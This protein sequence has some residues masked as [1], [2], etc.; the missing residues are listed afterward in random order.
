MQEERCHGVA[1][2]Q[3]KIK[4]DDATGDPSQRPTQGSLKGSTGVVE[5]A[6]TVLGIYR[7]AFYK[8]VP[9]NKLELHL[10]KQRYGRYPQ[11]VECDWDPEYGAIENGRT[12][13]V[14]R[15]GEKG[16][17]ES[18]LDDA[19]RAGKRGKRRQRL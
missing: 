18:F 10:L 9:D 4:G 3:I 16:A 2:H 15:P 19:E 6:S 14:E 1:V 8:S 5:A 12:I 17:V 7:P 13:E 11:A